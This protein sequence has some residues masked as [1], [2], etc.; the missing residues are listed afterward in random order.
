MRK[1]CAPRQLSHCHNWHWRQHLLFAHDINPTFASTLGFSLPGLS[2]CIAFD[3]SH[4]Q[5]GAA[6]EAQQE[7]IERL[8]LRLSKGHHGVFGHSKTP[9]RPRR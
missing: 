9:A 6:K 8:H 4:N 2:A 7:P 5:D 3:T 1:T